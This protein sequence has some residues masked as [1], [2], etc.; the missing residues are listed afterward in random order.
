MAGTMKDAV[1]ER[2]GLLGLVEGV[3]G[4]ARTRNSQEENVKLDDGNKPE[5]HDAAGRAVDSP[6]GPRGQRMAQLGILTRAQKRPPAP[7]KIRQGI[8]GKPNPSDVENGKM[9]ASLQEKYQDSLQ[10]AQQMGQIAGVHESDPMMR[11]QVLRAPIR[12]PR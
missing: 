7:I 2:S 4:K 11:S 9:Q 6:S 8:D 5:W 10:A 1:A 3:V 12:P